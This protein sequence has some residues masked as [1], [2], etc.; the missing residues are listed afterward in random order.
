MEKVEKR[1]GGLK[2]L[3]KLITCFVRNKLNNETSDLWFFHFQIHRI[4]NSDQNNSVQQRN[5]E[6]TSD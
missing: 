5:C 3:K 4:K 2:R 6:S 1:K